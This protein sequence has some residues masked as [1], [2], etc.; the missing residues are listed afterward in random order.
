M[1]F[2]SIINIQTFYSTERSQTFNSFMLTYSL[3]VCYNLTH[4]AEPDH[5]LLRS[6][7]AQGTCQVMCFHPW[8]DVT[9]PLMSISEIR[10][11]IDKWAE[12]NVDLGNKY[13]WVQVNFERL[14]CVTCK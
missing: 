12:I 14:N 8:S 4:S 7:T 1:L 9:L 13:N 3:C 5:P 10:A 2:M 6:E 11:V